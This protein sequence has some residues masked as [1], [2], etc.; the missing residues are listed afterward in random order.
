M[1]AG[2]LNVCF[3]ASGIEDQCEIRPLKYKG[4]RSILIFSFKI[5]T[6][7]LSKYA[8]VLHLVGI[9]STERGGA[10]KY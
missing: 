4:L 1:K 7:F 3:E 9:N 2:G 5:C 8:T 10:G 6:L